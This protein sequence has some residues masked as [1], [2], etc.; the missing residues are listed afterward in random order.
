MPDNRKSLVGNISNQQELSLIEKKK[1][2]VRIN[3]TS[4]TIKDSTGDIVDNWV[5]P[6][7]QWEMNR[8]S[9]QTIELQPSEQI[10]LISWSINSILIN[11][12]S[13]IVD[14]LELTITYDTSET[15]SMIICDYFSLRTSKMM[16]GLKIKNLSKDKNQMVKVLIYK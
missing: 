16:T 13:N 11:N 7:R 3:D 14:D 9:F 6:H 5:L 10:D 1:S 12:L 15:V 4:I 8:Y 2:I